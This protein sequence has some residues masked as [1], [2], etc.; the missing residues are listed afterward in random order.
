MELKFEFVIFAGLI[1]AAVAAYVVWR[2]A[3]YFL[4]RRDYYVNSKFG[5]LKKKILMCLG[6]ASVILFLSFML[7]KKNKLRSDM[8]LK[9]QKSRH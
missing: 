7:A 6:V 3:N 1:V 4:S 5:I 2:Y 9:T 8:Q